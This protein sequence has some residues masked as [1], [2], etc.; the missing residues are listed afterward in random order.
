[1]Y[2]PIILMEY[3]YIFAG[4]AIIYYIYQAFMTHSKSIKKQTPSLK[5]A[6]T[7]DIETRQLNRG[8][9]KMTKDQ[10]DNLLE[11]YNESLKLL[12]DQKAITEFAQNFIDQFDLTNRLY[13]FLLFIHQK[14]NYSQVKLR[15]WY[16]LP[17]N[18]KIGPSKYRT[19]AMKLAKIEVNYSESSSIS[20]YEIGSNYG[21]YDYPD[22]D[23]D[24]KIVITKLDKII[25]EV[26]GADYGKSQDP[27]TIPEHIYVRIFK[28]SNWLL[29]LHNFLLDFENNRD[30]L[31]QSYN[32]AAKKQAA[33]YAR[34]KYSSE[35]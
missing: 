20:G 22:H 1:M 3:V 15:E 32:L 30:K 5:P 12:D 35:Q 34:E 9:N 28:P 33:D 31:E 2:D 23:Y 24:K 11:N 8:M 26:D 27:R 21:P 16:V 14:T 17:A 13:T 7:Q 10:F 29:N 18:V 6:T 4:A 19:L 25:F